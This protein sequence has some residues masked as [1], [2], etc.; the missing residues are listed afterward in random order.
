VKA[1][2]NAGAEAR[3]V[4]NLSGNF[5]L[6]SGVMTMTDLTFSVP[7]AEVA[8]DGTLGLVSKALDFRGVAELDAKLSE[9]TTGVPSTVLE[10]ADLLFARDG[11]GAVFPVKITGTTD[12]PKVGLEL[13]KLFKR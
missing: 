8:L 1:E 2:K 10:F 5:V 3:V 7:G 4:S 9:M 6:E 13:G 12:D 11:K